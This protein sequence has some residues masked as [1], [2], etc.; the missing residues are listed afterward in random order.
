MNNMKNELVVKINGDS[1]VSL[2]QLPEKLQVRRI[3]PL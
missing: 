2:K 1:R 3:K